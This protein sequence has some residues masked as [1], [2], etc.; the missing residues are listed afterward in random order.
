MV[1]ISLLCTELKCKEQQVSKLDLRADVFLPIPR[2]KSPCLFLKWGSC[3]MDVG[4]L[5]LDHVSQDPPLKEFV[6]VT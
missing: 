3:W 5:S 2:K 4:L 1:S 6:V